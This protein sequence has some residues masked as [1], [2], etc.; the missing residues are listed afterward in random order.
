MGEGVAVMSRLRSSTGFTLIEII[1]VLAIVAVLTAIFIPLAV[2]QLGQAD[3]TR[4]AADVDA[5]ATALTTFYSDVRQFP[6]CDSSDCSTT[7][8]T[9]RFLAFG[10][11]TGDLSGSYPAETSSNW[12][13]LS[14]KD[15]STPARNNAFNHL[16]QNDPNAAGGPATS[17]DYRTN[18]W[19]GPYMTKFALDPWGRTYIA[20]VGAIAKG[21]SPVVTDGKGWI[22]SAGPD[23]TLNTGATDSTISGDDVGYIYGTN[24]G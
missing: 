7:N 1:F 19:N 3:L 2:N 23:N 11:G 17:T 16:G 21:G 5:I 22:I 24:A 9:L 18:K 20:H 6:T 4:A 14:T 10:D 13:T 8:K 15:S 12:G